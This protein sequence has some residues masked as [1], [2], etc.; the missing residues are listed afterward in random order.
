MYLRTNFSR[1]MHGRKSKAVGME[2]LEGRCQKGALLTYRQSGCSAL[3]LY[4]QSY[5]RNILSFWISLQR[6]TENMICARS[7]W[8]QK[9]FTPAGQLPPVMHPSQTTPKRP[10]VHGPSPQAS[11][12]SYYCCLCWVGE[13]K[14]RDVPLELCSTEP[15]LWGKGPPPWEEAGHLLHQ[16]CWAQFWAS[17]SSRVALASGEAAPGGLCPGVLGRGQ[18]R[19]RQCGAS[20]VEPLHSSTFPILQGFLNVLHIS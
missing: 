4:R 5:D 14:G 12:W 6:N 17:P 7:I 2:S 9:S 13:G 3:G 1:S 15:L 20:P 19:G 11:W 8:G 18:G 16:V 10:V